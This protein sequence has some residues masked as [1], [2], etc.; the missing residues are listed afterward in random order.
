MEEKRLYG[1]LPLMAAS[2]QY[3]VG[4]VKFHVV[5]MFQRT[6]SIEERL[7]DLMLEDLYAEGSEKGSENE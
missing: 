2:H 1:L 4:K 6:A 3:Q 7:A 5:S